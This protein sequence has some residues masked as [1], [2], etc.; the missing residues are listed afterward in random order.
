MIKKKPNPDRSQRETPAAKKKPAT[1]IEPMAK[2]P[3]FKSPPCKHLH[4]VP[5]VLRA[6][7]LT[8]AANVQ[9]VDTACSII[10]G[11]WLRVIKYYCP[12]CNK[13]I[14]PPKE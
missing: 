10:N 2:T 11:Q 6:E 7:R 12:E 14:V 9:I 3:K 8:F 5:H 13:Y 4:L 1:W